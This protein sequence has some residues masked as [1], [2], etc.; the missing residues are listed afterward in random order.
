[1]KYVHILNHKGHPCIFP[2]N[3]LHLHPE[4]TLVVEPKAPKVE[5]GTNVEELPMSYK[6][7]K[8]RAKELGIEYKG[9]IS[10]AELAVLLR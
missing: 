10:K 3:L 2:E 1:M 5:L 8:G 7:M 9:N 4:F 6:E